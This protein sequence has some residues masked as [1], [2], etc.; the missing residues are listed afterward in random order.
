[1]RVAVFGGTGFV[2]NYIIN[3]LLKSDY[4]VNVLVREGSESKLD[5]PDKCNIINGDIN[6]LES[7]D[8]TL[9]NCETVIYNIGIIREF[10]SKGITFKNLHYEGLKSVVDSCSKHHINRFVLMSANGVKPSGTGYQET[11][12]KAEVYL[13]GKI[14]DWTII[15]PSLIFGDSKGKMEFCSQLKKDMLSLPFPA[16][17]FFGGLNFLNAGEFKMSPIHVKDVAK[18]FVKCIENGH[19]FKKIYF[20]GGQ[21]YTWKEIVKTISSAY[22]KS[23]MM[24]PAPV[25]P[26]FIVALILDR[27]PWFPISSDQLSMLI[28][29]N[30]CDSGTIF[31]R[32]DIKPIDFKSEN[33]TY[34]K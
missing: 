3:E 9:E 4:K 7:I 34:L 25:L 32:Y 5:D 20:L 12:Y 13:R 14:R 26:I 27:Y 24:V 17:S 33:L 10:K 15:R 11:K 30:V 29:G 22:G 6:N 31:K 28:Q 2:G 8:K 1:M 19:S 16:P 23:K 21:D 18:V